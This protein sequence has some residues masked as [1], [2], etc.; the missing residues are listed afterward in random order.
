MFTNERGFTLVEA[1]VAMVV[2]TI[3]LVAMAEMMA[4][5]LRL[6]QLGR[7]STSAVRLAQDKIDELTTMPFD[8]A[9][10]LYNPAIACGGS[11]T[12]DVANHNDV[13]LGDNGTPHDAADDTFVKGYT[14]RWLISAGPDAD[15]DLR[16]VTVRVTPEN[17]DRRVAS[18]FDLTTI[19][20]GSGAPACP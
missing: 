13:P 19:I 2:C 5:T 11:L 4:V 12:G 10:P 15:P 18:P 8:P 16:T 14:R 20:R 1:M 9:T 17:N 3:G 7:N 6:Q